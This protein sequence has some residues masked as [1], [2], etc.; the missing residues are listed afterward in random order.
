MFESIKIKIKKRNTLYL[1]YKLLLFP[2]LIIPTHIKIMVCK[3]YIATSRDKHIGERCF[4]IGNGPSL[5]VNDLDKLENE[6]C[7]GTNAIYTIFQQVKWRPRYYCVQDG[8][9]IWRNSK[10]ISKISES[11]KFVCIERS[12]RYPRIVCAKYMGIDTERFYPNMPKFSEDI[13]ECIYEGFSVTYMCMQLAVYMGFK[14]IVLLG[15]DH[16]YSVELNPDGSLSYNESAQDH[17]NKFDKVTNVPQ[18]F[19]VEL[20]YRK[21]LE[22]SKE[23]DISIY[24][25]TRGGKLEIFERKSLEEILKIKIK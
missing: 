22:V 14:E 20:A 16:N 3:K 15:M 10:D 24:N 12:Y 21:A 4:I 5:S 2:I 1:M 13:S 7:F 8:K 18:L 17:F 11:Q 23:K 6:I 25:A 9:F 19:N